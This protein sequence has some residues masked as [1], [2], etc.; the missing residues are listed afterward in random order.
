MPEKKPVR[1][2]VVEDSVVQRK[3]LTMALEGKPGVEV[4][5]HASD[6]VQALERIAEGGVD[7]LTLD[8]EMPVMGGL[9]VLE[10]LRGRR[11]LVGAI[12]VSALSQQGARQTLEAMQ[13]GAFD[14][15]TKPHA[16]GDL[17]ATIARIEEQIVPRVLACGEYV[18]NRRRRAS[19][20]A[21]PSRSARAPRPGA[22]PQPLPASR[23]EEP[24]APEPTRATPAH[25]PP[26]PAAPRAE[27]PSASPVEE[28]PA[29]LP[30]P[31]VPLRSEQASR[32]RRRRVVRVSEPGPVRPEEEVPAPAERAPRARR[33]GPP[34]LVVIGSSTGGPTALDTLF[35]MLPGDLGVP[36]L[37]V[38]HMPPMFT[39][40]LAES[41]DRKSALRVMEATEGQAVLPGEALIAPGGR[42]M[43]VE[44]SL[45]EGL[46]VR[47]TDDPPERSCRPSVDY[48]FRSA[49]EVTRGRTVAA[50]LTGMGDDGTRGSR[51]LRP[52]GARII[53]QNEETCVVFG[54]PRLLVTEGIA[55]AVLPIEDI[56]AEIVAACR[57]RGRR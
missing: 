41:L 56:A 47:L 22:L 23:E 13:L 12:V 42:Q 1:V 7:V 51:L 34:E 20:V 45:A 32:P 28:P 54:M 53:A 27:T 37:V 17:A 9:E 10:N 2:L 25:E 43:R 49:S 21:A 40:T 16:G 46:R 19:G 8:L 5:G 48:L 44:R 52:L 33:S 6:G 18:E 24:A 4:V 15:I 30:G 35:S 36:V 26:R 29:P 50:V 11:P 39:K 57:R 38:Q 3:I 14:L 55:D 31:R